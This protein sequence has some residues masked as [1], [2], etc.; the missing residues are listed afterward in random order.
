M[1]PLSAIFFGD[2]KWGN[3]MTPTNLYK[4]LLVLVC[5]LCLVLIG[6]G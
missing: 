4:V 5:G 1:F 2:V 6:K 3:R